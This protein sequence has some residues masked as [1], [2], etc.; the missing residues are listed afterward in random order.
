MKKQNDINVNTLKYKS[1]IEEENKMAKIEAE[2]R[3]LVSE[4]KKGSDVTELKF[5]LKIQ[6]S[7]IP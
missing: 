6:S 7:E 5:R 3:D 1:L 4:V 2:R